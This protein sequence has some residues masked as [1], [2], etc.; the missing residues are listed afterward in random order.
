MWSRLI[1]CVGLACPVAA[2]TPIAEMVCLPRTEL[3][4][5]MKGAELAGSGLRDEAAVLEVWSE[6]SGDWTLV[7]SYANGMA[8]ILA[9]GEAWEATMPPPA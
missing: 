5:R 4:Q 6:P 9:M 8:C 7:Q 1:L 3:M 2:E